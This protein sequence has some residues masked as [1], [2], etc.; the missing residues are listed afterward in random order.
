MMRSELPSDAAGL[1][2]NCGRVDINLR[3]SF[4]MPQSNAS[5]HAMKEHS[6]YAH[7]RGA[8]GITENHVVLYSMANT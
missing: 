5:V 8:S 7:I 4:Y 6:A 3:D 2:K 1:G